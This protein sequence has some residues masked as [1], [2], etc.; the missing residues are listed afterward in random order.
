MKVIDL[1]R[2][3]SPASRVFP[4]SPLPSFLTW[5][6]L[7][8]HG[9]DS[10]VM[11]LSTHTGTHMDSPCHF[12]LSGKSIDQIDIKRFFSDHAVLL[13]IEKKGNEL[14]TRQDIIDCK[15]KIEENYTIIFETGWERHY[16]NSDYFIANPG[17]ADDAS[18]FLSDKKV[19]AVAIDGPS[20]DVGTDFNFTSHKILLSNDILVIE[21]LC[22]LEKLRLHE[23]FIFIVTPLKLVGSTGSPVR[24]IGIVE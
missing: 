7:D 14:I 12:V 16:S 19:N 8:T 11:F 22:S 17:L 3:I 2:E 4:G 10:E 18:Q 23:R 24:A 5:S 13:I 1:S 6:K 15:V 20:I 9:Y 21:N